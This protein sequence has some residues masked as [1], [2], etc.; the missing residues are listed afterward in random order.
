MSE[1]FEGNFSLYGIHFHFVIPTNQK[2]FFFLSFSLK[3]K[4]KEWH[5]WNKSEIRGQCGWI[6]TVNKF[7]I[8]LIFQEWKKNGLQSLKQLY[9]RRSI[10]SLSSSSWV[11]SKIKITVLVQSFFPC[12]SWVCLFLQ[13]GFSW[14]IFS[15]KERVLERNKRKEAQYKH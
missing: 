9:T 13:K 8:L 2:W 15:C 4:G 5:I 10:T 14:K 11:H 12:T 6:T 1:V 3:I 7:T